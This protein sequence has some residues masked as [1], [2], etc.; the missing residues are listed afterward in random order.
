ML[1]YS[2]AELASLHVLAGAEV[3]LIPQL[4]E[5]CFSRG[6]FQTRPYLL[7]Q[8]Q[9]LLTKS[10]PVRITKESRNSVNVSCL[11]SRIDIR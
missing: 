6:G 3:Q 1:F 11:V 8:F 9:L 2:L 5:V 7:F 4:L 10:L